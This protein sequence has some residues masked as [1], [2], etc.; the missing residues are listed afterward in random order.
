MEYLSDRQYQQA[1]RKTHDLIDPTRKSA[2]FA[3]AKSLRTQI[4][5]GFS[6]HEA[7]DE[8]CRIPL[9]EMSIAL[10][11]LLSREAVPLSSASLLVTNR[12]EECNTVRPSATVSER[13]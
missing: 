10:V 6:R 7:G 9:H 13:E 12:R 11:K 5:V 8:L 4:A 1:E 2:A 3:F